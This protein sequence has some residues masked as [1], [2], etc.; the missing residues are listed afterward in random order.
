M[1]KAKA[2][3]LRKKTPEELLSELDKLKQELQQLRVD[4]VTS[5]TA[6]KLAKIGEVRKSIA[7]YNTVIS[8]TRREQLKA[9]YKGKKHIPLDLR[10]KKT[11]A[12]RRGLT[13][14]EKSLVTLR[15]A[16]RRYSFPRRTYAL[17]A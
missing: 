13:K 11:R 10:T 17:S 2:Y 14:K 8:Q 3:Q 16:K 7:V 1:T 9:F 4:K 5:G 12:M 6:T 15:E